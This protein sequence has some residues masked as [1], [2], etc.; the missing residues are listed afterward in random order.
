[1][2]YLIHPINGHRICDPNLME[3]LF[4]SNQMMLELSMSHLETLS[5]WMVNL[6]LVFSQAMIS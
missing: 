6:N 3:I 2:L 5:M 1:M 4:A